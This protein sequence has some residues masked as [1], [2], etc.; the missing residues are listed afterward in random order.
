MF[1]FKDLCING[2][3]TPKISFFEITRWGG[4]S[5]STPGLDGS[6]F[7]DHTRYS[8]I[9]LKSSY[10]DLSNEGSKKLSSLERAFFDEFQILVP[11]IRAQKNNSSEFTEFSTKV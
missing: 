3:N 7:F 10:Q 4:G 1:L 9:V 11:L 5:N 2:R 6:E 8:F